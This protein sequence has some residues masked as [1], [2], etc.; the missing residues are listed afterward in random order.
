MLRDPKP[1]EYL[2]ADLA[3]LLAICATPLAAIC[4][5]V[6]NRMAEPGL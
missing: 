1:R 2:L 3:K 6:E 5:L 4:S